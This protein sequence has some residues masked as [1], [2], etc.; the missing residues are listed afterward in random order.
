MK[1]ARVSGGV[2]AQPGYAETS[3][4]LH[5]ARAVADTKAVLANGGVAT[6]EPG[7][8]GLS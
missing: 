2:I 8:A 1:I 7:L 6:A 5:P 3:V 4:P